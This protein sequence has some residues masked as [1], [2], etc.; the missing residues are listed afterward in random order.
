MAAEK[1]L[2]FA[3]SDEPAG[4]KVPRFVADA[5]QLPARH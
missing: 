5:A 2:I 1:T 3:C 4:R